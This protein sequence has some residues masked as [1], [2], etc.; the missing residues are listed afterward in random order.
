MLRPVQYN[1]DLYDTRALAASLPPQ[2]E[3]PLRRPTFEHIQKQTTSRSYKLLLGLTGVAKFA[4]V[5]RFQ[6]LLQGFR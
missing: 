6:A 4:S 2:S 5:R 1:E 3:A